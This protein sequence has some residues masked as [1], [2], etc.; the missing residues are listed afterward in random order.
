MANSFELR[1]LTV[2]N[3]EQSLEFLREHFFPFEPCAV[4]IGLCPYVTSSS[5][6]SRILNLQSLL[7]EFFQRPAKCTYLLYWHFFLYGSKTEQIKSEKN[8]E[9]M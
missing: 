8:R 2:D 5:H 9:N 6:F 7:R 4:N 3:F 1:P